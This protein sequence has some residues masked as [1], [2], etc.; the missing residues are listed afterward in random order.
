MYKIYFS[1]ECIPIYAK[2][3]IKVLIKAIILTVNNN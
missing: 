1:I 2:K 3:L